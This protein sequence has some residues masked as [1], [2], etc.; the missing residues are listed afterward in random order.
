MNSTN[1]DLE[2]TSIQL[3]LILITSMNVG[4][5]AKAAKARAR[6]GRQPEPLGGQARH[7]AETPASQPSRQPPRPKRTRAKK[8][9]LDEGTKN[10]PPQREMGRR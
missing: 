5:L 3:R 2:W 10:Q 9:R 8:P 1:F 4:T 6:W 7:G